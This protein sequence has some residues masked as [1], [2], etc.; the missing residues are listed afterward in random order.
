MWFLLWQEL[1]TSTSPSSGKC[2]YALAFHVQTADTTNSTATWDPKGTSRL[3]SSL[4]RDWLVDVRTVDW[5]FGFPIIST[6]G[7]KEVKQNEGRTST[8]FRDWGRTW[9]SVAPG[10]CLHSLRASIPAGVGDPLGATTQCAVET[11]SITTHDRAVYSHCCFSSLCPKCSTLSAVLRNLIWNLIQNRQWLPVSLEHTLFLVRRRNSP[12]SSM[13]DL[14]PSLCLWRQHHPRGRANR[15]V[16]R[17]G[18][19]AWASPQGLRP[20]RQGKG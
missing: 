11:V 15:C 5:S 13:I 3:T 19:L 12:D 1:D 16:H 9:S 20:P 18:V 8:Q 17:R 2:V 4:I 6:Q 7:W 14:R 10:T